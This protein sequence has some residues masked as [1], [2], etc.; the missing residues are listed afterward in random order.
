M[1]NTVNTWGMKELTQSSCRI[2]YGWIVIFT[3]LLANIGSHGFSRMAYSL[4]LP[5]MMEGLG[6][7]YT[8]AGLLGTSNFTGYLIFV[9]AGG[10]LAS[11]FG[12]RIVITLSML[13]IGISMILTGQAQS[14]GFALVMRFLTGL[15]NGGV[16]VPA[17]SLGSA[18]FDSKQRGFATG[19]IAGGT[20]VGIM[21]SGVI[22]PKILSLHNVQGW[23][24]AWSYMGVIVL[25]ICAL[26]FFLLRNHPEEMKLQ[27]VGSAACNDAAPAAP[28]TDTPFQWEQVYKRKEVQQLGVV[29]FANGFTYVI[30]MT[31]FKAFL[32]VEVGLP[33]MQ[34]AAMWALAGSFSIFSAAIWGAVSDRLGRKYALALVFFD[35]AMSFLLFALFDS[36][37]PLYISVIFFGTSLGGIP[38]IMGATAGDYVGPRLAPAAFGFVTLFFAIGQVLGPVFGGYLIFY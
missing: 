25:L 1:Y 16:F 3:G 5:E 13:L 28:V 22:V 29:Y 32:T 10:F 19:I 4:V 14:F 12:S 9:V 2:H 31:F 36:L 6:L 17:L 35:F 33:E 24:Y 38:T 21:L 18:W 7:S 8:Q 11:R 26:C 34:A 15:G 27:P 20:G 30:Y 23:S 37:F